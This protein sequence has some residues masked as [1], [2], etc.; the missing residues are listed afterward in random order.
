VEPIVNAVQQLLEDREQLVQTSSDLIELV[1][2][3]GRINAPQKV[4]ETAISMLTADK[5]L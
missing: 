1:E 2:P 5:T 3:L 4:A